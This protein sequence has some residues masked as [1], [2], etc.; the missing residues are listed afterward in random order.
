[1]DSGDIQHHRK[2][3]SFAKSF[4]GS[5]TRRE[6]VIGLCKFLLIIPRLSRAEN[7]EPTEPWYS[8]MKIP[9]TW[10][11]LHCLCSRTIISGNRIN[12]RSSPM[13]K[14]TRRRLRAWYRPIVS[15]GTKLHAYEHCATVPHTALYMQDARGSH[16]TC[17]SHLKCAIP[18][19]T[20]GCYVDDSRETADRP[21]VFLEII[22]LALH[23]GKF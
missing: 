20:V 8:A 6:F 18:S 9:D 3:L 15:R 10:P 11:T 5:T 23:L 14:M 17:A 21:N 1:M 19:H 7:I 16:S 12:P 2:S 22:A 4:R 13:R